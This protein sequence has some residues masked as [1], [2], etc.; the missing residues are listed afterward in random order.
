ME[1]K[2]F[3]TSPG[4]NPVRLSFL[5][6]F[7]S[8]AAHFIAGKVFLFALLH[9]FPIPGS[10][11]GLGYGEASP[12]AVLYIIKHYRVPVLFSN[13][14]IQFAVLLALPVFLIRRWHTKDV[15]GY[16]RFRAPGILPVVLSI[17][18]IIFILPA[19]SLLSELMYRVFPDFEK[20][21]KASLALIR[22]DT[23]PELIFSLLSLSVTP[24]VCEEIL[25]RGYFQRTLHGKIRF[26]YHI[27]IS[28]L[29]FA[30]YHQRIS[31][32][33]VFFL[34]GLYF[35]FLYYSF[36]SIYVSMT[37]HFVYNLLIILNVNF[38]LRSGFPFS[39]EGHF[40][41]P[42]FISLSCLFMLNTAVVY[43]I[44]RSKRENEGRDLENSW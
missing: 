13:A 21:E 34:L 16:L 30:F 19:V 44:S 10:V 3:F 6:L 7:I 4:K 23:L 11:Y 20:M 5:V 17:T 14:L 12:E 29:F 31:G 8:W 36:D 9:I 1:K 27:I 39:G 32:F 40:I 18:G 28:G 22:T 38:P 43:F 41:M 35:G 15:K 24:A 33:P 25:F 42:V 2:R 37:A 26:P